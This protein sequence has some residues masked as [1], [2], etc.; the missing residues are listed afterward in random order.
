[1][2]YPEGVIH[3]EDYQKYPDDYGVVFKLQ[4]AG[5]EIDEKREEE[6]NNGEPLTKE[7]EDALIASVAEDDVDSWI[8]HHGFEIAL[9]DGSLFTHFTGHS[10]GQGGVDFRYEGAFN[11]KAALIDHIGEQFLASFQ[12]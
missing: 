1:M 3:L 7:E 2:S 12:V 8:G 6:I 11:N 9:K 10:M 5:L 4:D